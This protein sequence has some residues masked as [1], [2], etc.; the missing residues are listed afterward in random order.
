M[1]LTFQLNPKAYVCMLVKVPAQSSAYACLKKA[2]PPAALL[3][4]RSPLITKFVAAWTMPK[5]SN[6]QQRS[7]AQE[8][9]AR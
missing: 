4:E 6:K 1:A 8:P 3:M 2:N 7:I 9:E 5:C